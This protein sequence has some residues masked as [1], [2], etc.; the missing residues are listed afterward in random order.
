MYF[1]DMINLETKLNTIFKWELQGKLSN[2]IEREGKGRD[3]RRHFCKILYFSMTF[4]SNIINN[5]SNCYA[6]TNYNG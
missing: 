6:H 1:L 4:K 2:K 5:I 3:F